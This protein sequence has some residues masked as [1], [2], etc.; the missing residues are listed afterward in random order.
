MNTRLTVVDYSDVSTGITGGVTDRAVAASPAEQS[1]S[2]N[3]ELM[4][5][6]NHKGN[7][8]QGM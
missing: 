4:T 8:E 6:L 7:L 5:Q 2:A 1:A 3:R